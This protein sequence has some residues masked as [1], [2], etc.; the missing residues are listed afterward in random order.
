MATMTNATIGAASDANSSAT[1]T[2]ALTTNKGKAATN[3]VGAA[4]SASRGARRRH[5]DAPGGACRSLRRASAD[6]TGP[7]VTPK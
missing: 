4:Q 1:L 6:P 2:G 7:I 5:G 3:S